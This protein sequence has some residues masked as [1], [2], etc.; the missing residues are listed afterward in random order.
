MRIKSCLAQRV[1]R[2]F[3]NIIHW[4]L[5]EYSLRHNQCNRSIV[6]LLT[7]FPFLI[8]PWNSPTM[9]IGQSSYSIPLSIVTDSETNPWVNQAHQGQGESILRSCWAVRSQTPSFHLAI[10]QGCIEPH[11]PE[12]QAVV[13]G[14]QGKTCDEK[15][16][17]REKFKCEFLLEILFP[18]SLHTD[19]IKCSRYTIP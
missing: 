4:K 17:H 19:G 16:T 9:W 13:R 6:V 2:G 15:E 7:H 5:L 14:P 3:K 12:V 11:I 1:F 18:L 8:L 10:K